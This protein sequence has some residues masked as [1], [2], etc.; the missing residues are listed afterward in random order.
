LHAQAGEG[1]LLP[2]QDVLSFDESVLCRFR[3]FGTPRAAGGSPYDSSGGE[4]ID[5]VEPQLD[6]AA[7]SR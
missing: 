3:D 1:E 7:T 4:P 2:E 5:V 6:E